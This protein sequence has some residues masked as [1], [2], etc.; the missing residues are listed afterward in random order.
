MFTSSR[1]QVSATSS[2]YWRMPE[3]P[4][5]ER[6]GRA[7]VGAGSNSTSGSVS[8]SMAAISRLENASKTRMTSATLSGPLLTGMRGRAVRGR[9]SPWTECGRRLEAGPDRGG[10]N[11]HNG[12]RQRAQRPV[13][14]RGQALGGQLHLA[15]VRERLRSAHVQ[16]AAAQLAHGG[17][18]PP[19]REAQ[20]KAAGGHRQA[21]ETQGQGVGPVARERREGTPGEGEP[22]VR[23]EAPTEQLEVV[24]HHDERARGHEY[25][26]RGRDGDHP[27]H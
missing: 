27:R 14:W 4:R 1:S 24:G 9:A 22:D 12:H 6:C 15:P 20:R 2:K 26:Y 8:S 10:R 11:Q 13:E 5:Y 25:G 17:A 21:R 7:K 3:C 16:R 18:E 19:L 23:V